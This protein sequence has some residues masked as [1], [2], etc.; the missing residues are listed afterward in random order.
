MSNN[1]TRKAGLILNANSFKKMMMT[2][3]SK[4]SCMVDFKNKE[5]NEVTKKRPN[6]SL[7][8]VVLAISVEKMIIRLLNSVNKQQ[9]PDKTTGLIKVSEYDLQNAIITD[10]DLRTFY[11][12]P[13]YSYD[14]TSHY[15]LSV[16]RKEFIALINNVGRNLFID[17]NA[18]NFLHYLIKR[19]CDQLIHIAILFVQ[20]SKKRTVSP[21]A[22]IHAIE[23]SF[24]GSPS[25]GFSRYL[26]K[27]IERV[28]LELK[29]EKDEK[30]EGEEDDDKDE[31]DNKDDDNK[32][33]DN[34]DDENGGPAPP[35][36]KSSKK[37]KPKK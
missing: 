32:D 18:L 31:D 15:E 1:I 12:H 10:Y 2:V 17:D 29:D 7:A 5:T 11:G 21:I 25:D 24:M 9:S 35:D 23:V 4:E 26:S 30:L 37:S 16:D 8:H 13:P 33:D 22:I 27:E 34:K 28:L 36:T 6:I 19:Y 20:H 14:R 3:Y